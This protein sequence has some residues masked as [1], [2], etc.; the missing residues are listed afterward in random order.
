MQQSE[1]SGG[2]CAEVDLCHPFVTHTGIHMFG[3][4]AAFNLNSSLYDWNNNAKS[5]FVYYKTDGNAINTA[6]TNFTG[7]TL[8]LT[9]GAGL[10]VGALA[11]AICMTATKKKKEQT[12]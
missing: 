8:A 6:G 1:C 5:V 10:A 2:I 12:A 3:S 7:G 9:G 4:N 11:T